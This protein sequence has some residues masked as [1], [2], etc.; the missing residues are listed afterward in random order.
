MHEA[1]IKDVGGMSVAC[2]SLRFEDIFFFFLYF[3]QFGE[4]SNVKSI[5]KIKHIVYLWQ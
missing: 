2:P 3:T 1:K 4:A 5:G